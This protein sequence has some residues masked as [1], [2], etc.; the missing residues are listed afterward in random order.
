MTGFATGFDEFA[1]IDTDRNAQLHL[2]TARE[3]LRWYAE[4]LRATADDGARQV[5]ATLEHWGSGSRQAAI[6]LVR[7]SA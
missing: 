3:K 2:D 6:L 7:E 4:A 5:Q 1:E